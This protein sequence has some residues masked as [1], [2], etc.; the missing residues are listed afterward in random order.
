MTRELKDFE[1]KLKRQRYS[2][3]TVKTYVSCL[4]RF[5]MNY[6]DTNPNELIDRDVQIFIDHLIEKGYSRSTQ[7]Q[8]INAIKYYFE[9]VLGRPKKKYEFDRPRK[10]KKL[11][12]V[13]SMQEV[14][15]ILQTPKLAKHRCLLS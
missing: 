11:P 10:E 9:H 6:H 5:F 12:V 8:Y 15:A 7:N 2:S 13:L 14:S 4:Q 1:Q 3:H